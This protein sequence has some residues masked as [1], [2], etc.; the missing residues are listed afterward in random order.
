MDAAAHERSL[1]LRA[2]S[3]DRH[4][5]DELLRSV[6]RPLLRYIAT[7]AG[8]RVAAEDVLQDVL[9][10]VVRKIEWLRDPSLFRPWVF[11]IA[12]RAAFRA[13]RKAQGLKRDGSRSHPTFRTTMTSTSCSTSSACTRPPVTEAM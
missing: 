6:D 1:V 5:F 12:S 11:R 7:I 8:G 10:A 3:G 9:I 2:Q 4:A 13:I